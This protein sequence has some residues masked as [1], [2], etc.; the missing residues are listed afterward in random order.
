MEETDDC[1]IKW[2]AVTLPEAVQCHKTAGPQIPFGRFL[3]AV[4]RNIRPSGGCSK[5]QR[6]G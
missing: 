1:D 2:P 5:G 4:F 3:L 6:G